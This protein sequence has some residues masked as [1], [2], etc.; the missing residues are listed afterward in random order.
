MCCVETRNRNE[1][2][3]RSKL[4]FWRTVDY[5]VFALRVLQDAFWTKHLLV[6]ETVKLDFFLRVAL[7]VLDDPF[8]GRVCLRHIRI[9]GGR[10]GQPRQNLVVHGQIVRGQLVRRLVVRAL[11]HV[12]LRQLATTLQAER[13]TTWQRKW[14]LIVVIVW[15]E[16]DATL[17]YWIHSFLWSDWLLCFKFEI[18]SFTFL[19]R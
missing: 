4:T 7:A 18:I 10:H 1:N 19:D 17:K 8:D 15:L 14:L 12:V 11:D 5:L 2:V 16:T 3:N 9:S 13:V 6:W